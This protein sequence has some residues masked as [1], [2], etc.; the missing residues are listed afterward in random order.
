MTTQINDSAQICTTNLVSD[1]IN[2]T[3]VNIVETVDKFEVRQLSGDIQKLN[4]SNINATATKTFETTNPDL[5]FALNNQY[6]GVLDDI[7]GEASTRASVVPTISGHTNTIE[8]DEDSGDLTGTLTANKPV[9]WSIHRHGNRSESITITE[10]GNWTYKPKQDEY[11]DDSFEVKALTTSG[12]YNIVEINVRLTGV[13][14]KPT[15]SNH[16]VT[17]YEDT[18]IEF[19]LPLATDPDLTDTIGYIITSLPDSSIGSISQD[20]TPITADTIPHSLTSRENLLFTPIENKNGTVNFNYKVNDG[21]I[22]S[23]EST[24]TINISPVNDI[25]TASAVLSLV[26]N[27]NSTEPF[28]LPPAIDVDNEQ[29]EITFHITTL[30]TKGTLKHTVSGVE[31]SVAANDQVTRT[32]LKYEGKLNEYGS[33]SFKY[34]YNDGVQFS[35]EIQVDVTINNPIDVAQ[36][37]DGTTQMVIDVRRRLGS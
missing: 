14:D 26:L 9:T 23:E 31:K 4:T 27:K 30:P 36:L 28:T 7:I 37:L 6:A 10:S 24:V 29:N 21:T 11:G 1:N 19:S 33:D 22:D 25:P 20:G 18:S 8:G 16:T 15:T 5:L 2:T 12:K 3:H 17:A 32:D 34:K 35:N 13:N